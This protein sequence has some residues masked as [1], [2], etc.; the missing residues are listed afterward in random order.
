MS[1]G[2]PAN[3]EHAYWSPYVAGLGIGLTLLLT[4]YIMGHGLGAS[5]AYTQLTA[6]LLQ[7][8]TPDHA[9][10][11]EYLKD[12]LGE[13]FWQSWIVIEMLGVF[14]GGL[15]GALTA[16]RFRFQIER[17]PQASRGSRLLLALAGGIAVGFGSRVAMGCTSGQALSGGAVL[18][19]GSWL[20]TLTFF[21]GGYLFALFVRR[22]WQ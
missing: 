3:E 12:Y 10:T 22:E 17:G 4:F 20:F 19:I 14:L 8:V 7:R 15:L 13:S 21:L 2:N 5:G 18:A 1:P 11:N 9:Q 16:G 6:K